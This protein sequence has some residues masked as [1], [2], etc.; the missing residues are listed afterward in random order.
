[1]TPKE[2]AKYLALKF[3][4]NTDV[5]KP[6]L[7]SIE[8]ALLCVDEIQSFIPYETYKDTISPYD[9]AELSTNYWDEVKHELSLLQLTIGYAHIYTVTMNSI[10]INYTLKYEL[11]FS[12]KYQW[13]D[14]GTCFN[15][16][17]VE[18]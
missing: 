13:T 11:S 1:M 4:N 6:N 8:K 15:I 9:G 16:K 12:S 7:A 5:F 14:C 17:L 18:K 10:S 2:K 3:T